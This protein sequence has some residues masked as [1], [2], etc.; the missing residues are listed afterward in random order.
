MFA[1]CF[2]ARA[3]YRGFDPG[4]QW[5]LAFQTLGAIPSNENSYR[6]YWCC[7]SQD[8]SSGV[9]VTVI[10]QPTVKVQCTNDHI[11]LQ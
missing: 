5:G 3:A 4:P 9:N 1:N 10:V 7:Y 8:W 2:S 11:A 6:C